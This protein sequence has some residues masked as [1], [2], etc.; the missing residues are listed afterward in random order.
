DPWESAI[1]NAA[2]EITGNWLPSFPC[3]LL[4]KAVAS[5]KVGTDWLVRDDLLPVRA[6]YLFSSYL[7]D[8]KEQL[9]FVTHLLYLRDI[10]EN[11]EINSIL[12]DPIVFMTDH[13]ANFLFRDSPV[14]ICVNTDLLRAANS[15]AEFLDVGGLLICHKGNITL[16]DGV[17]TDVRYHGSEMNRERTSGL[18]N[19]IQ[20]RQ[21]I[22]FSK[23]AAKEIAP[24]VFR[25]DE[26]F[27]ELVPDTEVWDKLTR[28][29]AQVTAIE[30]SENGIVW[31]RYSDGSETDIPKQEFDLNFVVL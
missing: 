13:L 10:L 5:L 1:Q 18:V 9:V 8:N 24:D 4:A 12:H 15:K 23:A 2:K 3:Q 6:H 28:S 17:I 27:P 21:G 11:K 30:T 20:K 19:D 22:S 25:I 16:D 26:H 31:L 7:A 29:K 14:H